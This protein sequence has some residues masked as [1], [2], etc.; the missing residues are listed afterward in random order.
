MTLLRFFELFE[1][2]PII[3]APFV[4]YVLTEGFTQ[5]LSAELWLILGLATIVNVGWLA[6]VR[7]Q[8]RMVEFYKKYPGFRMKK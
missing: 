4:V 5:N 8:R 6:L 1:W 2:L 3:V 7:G